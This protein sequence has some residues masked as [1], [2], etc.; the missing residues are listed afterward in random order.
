MFLEALLGHPRFRDGR[1]TTR[2]I[3]ETPE[4]FQ[5]AKPRDRA[6]KLLGY[7]AD[8]TING[9]PE[10]KGRAKPRTTA[11]EPVPPHFGGALK[12][13]AGTKQLL[14]ELG[15]KR[16]AEKPPCSPLPWREPWSRALMT[17]TKVSAQILKRISPANL[18]F[19]DYPGSVLPFQIS[20][21]GRR[22]FCQLK[23][24]LLSI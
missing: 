10:V 8:I 21:D 24:K 2:F 17:G 18:F 4:L 12:A 16:F 19:F 6:T 13:P 11:R 9:H 14:T 22:R 5:V 7:I 1:Y 3:D 15:P 20:N 23:S